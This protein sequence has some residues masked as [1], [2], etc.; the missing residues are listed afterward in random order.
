MNIQEL[1]ND[2]NVTIVDVRTEGEFSEGN[3]NGS[4]NIPLNEVV[5]RIEELKEMQ[6]MVLCCLSGGRSG[7]ATAYLQ[8][9]GCDKVY[10]GG[11]WEIVNSMKI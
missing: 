10:N 7:Q 5:D 4:I 6:P 1:I 8:S 3:V 2:S 9:S 11:G